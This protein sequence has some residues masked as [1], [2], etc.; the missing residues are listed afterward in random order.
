[1]KRIRP[2][3]ILLFLAPVCYLAISVLVVLAVSWSGVY[4]SGSDTM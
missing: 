1:M 2:S 4:P 3:N